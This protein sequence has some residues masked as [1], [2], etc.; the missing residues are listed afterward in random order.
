MSFLLE[1]AKMSY[2][3][4]KCFWKYKIERYSALFSKMQNSNE[5][6]EM[7]RAATHVRG[8]LYKK[9]IKVNYD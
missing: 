2:S 3:S 5:V 8:R 9:V 6:S 1:N 4:V 7:V